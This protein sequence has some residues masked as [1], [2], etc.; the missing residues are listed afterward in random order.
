MSKVTRLLLWMLLYLAIALNLDQI[1]FNGQTWLE[2][3]PL[4]YFFTGAV[5]V[6][7][8]I[9]SSL[10]QM[11]QLLLMATFSIV[12]IALR[13]IIRQNTVSPNESDQLYG[14]II[15]LALLNLGIFLT[16]RFTQYLSELEDLINI[17]ILG[18]SKRQIFDLNQVSD[19]VEGEFNRG[20][21]YN[22]P[23]SAL[24]IDS[25]VDLIGQINASPNRVIEDIAQ[26]IKTK[27]LSAR[28]TKS[29]SEQIRQSDMVVRLD[30]GS[31]VL[32]LFPETSPENARMLANRLQE[33]AIRELGISFTYGIASF[34]QDAL[35]FRAVLN[36]AE[37]ELS[38]IVKTEMKTE[39]EISSQSKKQSLQPK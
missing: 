25:K 5:V 21:R 29:I 8:L 1:G 23:I 26:R 33:R 32:V 14:M 39:R 31:K 2:L 9:I 24:V 22:Y 15:E 13:L 4:V 20:R 19:M 7:C 17:S 12:Y 38:P 28:L 36:K 10:R 37:G 11:P 3:H 34:P 6:L 27:Y 30:K 16:H 18:Q 35:T